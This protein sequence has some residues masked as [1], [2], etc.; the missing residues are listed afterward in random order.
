[1]PGMHVYAIP[2]GIRAEPETQLKVY[3]VFKHHRGHLR[4]AGLNDRS[5]MALRLFVQ[6]ITKLLT[7]PFQRARC[8]LFLEDGE[9]FKGSCHRCRL[10]PEGSGNEYAPRG[11]PV[12][13]VAQNGRKRLTVGNAL[14]PCRKVRLYAMQRPTGIQRQAQTSAD[15]IENQRCPLSITDFANLTGEVRVSQ[16]LLGTGVMFEA[17]WLQ[18]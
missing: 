18:T 11:V 12:L 14:T 2:Q 16:L 13:V 1:M 7:Q 15:V 8:I 4:R 9:S 5:S 6:A 10:I 17:T 3:I